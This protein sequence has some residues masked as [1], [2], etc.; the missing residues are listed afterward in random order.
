VVQFTRLTISGIVEDSTN[1]KTIMS[2]NFRKVRQ[3]KPLCF[4]SVTRSW[5]SKGTALSWQRHSIAQTFELPFTAAVCRAE[6]DRTQIGCGR[7]KPHGGILPN[8]WLRTVKLC[9]ASA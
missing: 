4:L 2:M 8:C 3:F 9:F 5:L 1:P 7:P 6:T